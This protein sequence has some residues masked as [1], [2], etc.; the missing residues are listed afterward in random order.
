MND[1]AIRIKVKDGEI[2][3]IMEELTLAQDKIM[4]CYDRLRE[5]GVLTIEKAT[6]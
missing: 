4:E 1:V 2:E 3:R 5:L 6:S